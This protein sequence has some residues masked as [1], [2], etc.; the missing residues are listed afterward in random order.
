MG[1]AYT[2][3]LYSVIYVN[4]LSFRARVH[5]DFAVYRH[6]YTHR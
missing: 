4:T 6:T 5:I 3:F 1:G 2:K